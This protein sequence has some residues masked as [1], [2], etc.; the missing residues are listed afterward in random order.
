MLSYIRSLKLLIYFSQYKIAPTVNTKYEVYKA[1][2]HVALA[3]FILLSPH[4]KHPGNIQWRSKLCQLKD[5]VV[6]CQDAAM[7]CEYDEA[8]RTQILSLIE[9]CTLLLL[10]MSMLI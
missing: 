3:I 8:F 1:I 5:N 7:H 9:V 2:S 4:L 10:I 6:V